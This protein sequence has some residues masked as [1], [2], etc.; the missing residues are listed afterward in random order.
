MYA[1]P[2]RALHAG[3]VLKAEDIE[4]VAWPGSDPIEGALS[5]AAEII[6]RE[7]PV[8]AG[9]RPAHPG[10]RPVCRRGRHRPSQQ[11]SGRNARR[12]AALR[13]GSRGGRISGSRLASRRTGDLPLGH[14][15]RACHRDRTAGRRRPGC[16]PPARTRPRGQDVG[17]NGGDAVADSGAGG[18]R[19]S[20]KHSGRD[21]LCAAQRSGHKPRR[22]H[23]DACCRNSPV[24]RPPQR[25][26]Y[27]VR[28]HRQLRQPRNNRRSKPFLEAATQ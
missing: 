4:L 3:E 16:R 17:R 28:L 10:R 24:R 5:Q 7:V 18:A 1:A 14:L 9:Q 20:G 11:D 8:S 25:T 19:R 2:S 6:G 22:R 15:A 26:S 13:R 12:R 27:P 21:P 23:S